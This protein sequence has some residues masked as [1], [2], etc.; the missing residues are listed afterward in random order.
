M[1][2][3]V[4]VIILPPPLHFL[5][6][7]QTWKAA[8]DLSIFTQKVK[9]HCDDFEAQEQWSALSTALIHEASG[10]QTP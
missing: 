9:I 3:F 2:N 5:L 10:T 1:G 8:G 6:M 7:P 4:E